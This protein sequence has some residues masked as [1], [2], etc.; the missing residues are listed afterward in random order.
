MPSRELPTIDLR[1]S[2]ADMGFAHGRALRDLLATTFREAY[3]DRLSP[4]TRTDR[5][6][7]TRQAAAWLGALPVR[8]QAE[9]DGMAAGAGVSLASVS[10]FL[11][12]D[13]AGPTSTEVAD[14]NAP[15][16]LAGPLCSAV[17]VATGGSTWIGR[18]CDWLFATLTRGVAGVVHRDPNRIP[19][20]AVGIRG[21]IDVDTGINAER[22]WL[23]LHTLPALD[24]P[25]RGKPRTSWLFWARDA[26]E[27]CATLDALEEFIASTARDRGVIVVA[28]D[29]KSGDAAVFEC[30]RG[31]YVRHD[32][33]GPALFATNHP[34]AKEIDDAREA[35]S[36][37]EST[38]SRYCA[39]RRRLDS[40]TPEAMP[41]DLIGL[42]GAP[43]VEMRSARHL[44]T[45]YS[46]VC[47]PE[48]GTLWFASGDA[49]GRPAASAGAWTRVRWPF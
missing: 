11:Y 44:R 19:I 46:A 10:E 39:L 9:I 27:T 47:R 35:K 29:G 30:S 49:G 24:D 43:D 33:R 12:A 41:D 8:F 22:L 5:A 18:N 6:D 45:I 4:V 3:L 15:A 1:G 36:R 28:A 23:H 21:D 20:L 25:P 7:L 31:D 42:L 14:P 16:P 13:I 26:L 2:S 37:P 17:S 34:L 32:Q 40:R 38:V 48:S